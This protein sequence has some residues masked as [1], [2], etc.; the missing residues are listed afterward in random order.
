MVPQSC[1]AVLFQLRFT[2]QLKVIFSLNKVKKLLAA[3]VTFFCDASD[4]KQLWLAL[5]NTQ[6]LNVFT[7]R[8][9]F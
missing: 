4:R 9:I 6:E 8:N 1:K 7:V 5:E 2:L 3:Q